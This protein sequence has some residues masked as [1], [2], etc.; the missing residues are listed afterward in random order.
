MANEMIPRPEFP[1]PDFVRQDWQCLNG[2]WAF[3]FDEPVF[4][5]T[6][7][8]PF[9]YQAPMSGIGLTEA[10][11]VVWYRR[12]FSAEGEKL[13]AGRL[14]LKFGAVDTRADVWVNGHYV[15][16]HTG[17][18]TS[19]ALDITDAARAGENELL[20]KATDHSNADKPRGKQ[21]WTGERFGCWYTPTTGIWQSVWLE[22]TAR[23][24]LRR[25]KLTPNVTELTA[26]CEL[27]VSAD[28]PAEAQVTASI[29]EGEARQELCRLGIPCRHGY[30]KGVLAFPDWDLRRN[31]LCW[32]P[33]EPNLVD[34]EITLRTPGEQK[35]DAVST[36]FGLRSLESANGCLTL[37]ENNYY[38]RLVLDQGYWPES[39][40][41]PP[42]DA[43][44][45][46]DIELTKQLGFNGARKHQKI[47]DPRYYYW[48]DKLGLLV[49]GEL[50][51][52]YMFNDNAVEA[53]SRELLEF[54]ERDYNHPS[55]VVWVPVNESWGVRGIQESRQQQDYCRMLT[56]LLKAIDPVR[57]VSAN[58]GW[59]QI[60]ETDICAVHDYALFPDSI[61][62]YE[63]METRLAACTES[64]RL[65]AR[66]N[67][68]RGQPVMLTEYG[69]IAF[70][71]AQKDGWGYY[72]AVKNEAEFLAR[73]API[74]QFL[75]RSGKFAGFCYTQLTDVMQEVNGLL[76]EERAWKLAPE[77]LREIFAQSI[78]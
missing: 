32:T 65:F 33:E 60:S 22:Y 78:F 64:R 4:D 20:V 30:G 53:S 75:V 40:L 11:D 37:N 34:V 23:V 26:L 52:A 27:F 48:A 5:R 45:R 15:G 41:T 31:E 42:S 67:A 61:G 38:Q 68:W 1:R 25:V 66:G 2:P 56:Y 18:H 69:G 73:L 47:E 39:L 51:S 77:K 63:N 44:I 70:A 14:L 49:W 17:G 50:P 24:Y 3:S 58:D 29:G 21:T 19:F 76:T 72:G 16:S 9:C 74:T 13:A 7:T 35:E 55:I 36:Y 6:I 8:V 57:L 59:E 12:R 28:G 62:K 46:R 43:A 54:V 10:H 71:D